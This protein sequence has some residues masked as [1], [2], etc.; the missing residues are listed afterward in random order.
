MLPK[1]KAEGILCFPRFLRLCL[2][3]CSYPPSTAPSNSTGSHSPKAKPLK[4][5]KL[6][7]LCWRRGQNKLFLLQLLSWCPLLKMWL[8]LFPDSSRSRGR[9]TG[10]LLCPYVRPLPRPPS[11]GS[12]GHGGGGTAQA[13]TARHPNSPI[14]TRSCKTVSSLQQAGLNADASMTSG[15]GRVNGMQFSN[16]LTLGCKHRVEGRRRVCRGVRSALIAGGHTPPLAMASRWSFP[17]SS[18]SS[19]GAA[20]SGTEAS[21]EP[22]RPP[23]RGTRAFP[24]RH[25]RT[26][27]D[28]SRKSCGLWLIGI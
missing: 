14:I 2:E 27:A 10:P 4:P 28:Y 3:L 8:S 6:L 18:D 25:L 20:A 11:W 7:G 26:N 16:Q 1:N 15:L 21:T 12:V 23:G 24:V 19:E 5:S 17:S 22:R 9:S 13:R